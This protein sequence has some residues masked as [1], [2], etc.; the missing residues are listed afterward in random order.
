MNP[1]NWLWDILKLF[2]ILVERPGEG[3]KKKKEA[4]E[5]M[6]ELYDELNLQIPREVYHLIVDTAIDYLA[7]VLF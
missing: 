3:E 4:M 1:L 5:L 6:D 7:L 2:M